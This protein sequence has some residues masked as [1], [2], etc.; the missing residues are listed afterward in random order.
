[1]RDY[2]DEYAKFQSSP[3]SIKKRTNLNRENHQRNTYGNN[4]KLDVSHV[5]GGVKLEPQ[6]TNRGRKEKSRMKGSKRK[7]KNGGFPDSS[8]VGRTLQKKHLSKKATLQA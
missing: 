1:M 6:S 4:D 2:K 5:N 3:S 8:D 7:L